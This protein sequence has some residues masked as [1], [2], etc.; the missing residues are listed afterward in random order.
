[1]KQAAVLIIIKDKLILSI[2]RKNNKNKFAL[3]GGKV[4]DGETPEQAIVR[5]VKEE[6]DIDLLKIQYISTRIA[7]KETP[8]GEDFHCH[9]FYAL[10]WK[11]EPKGLEGHE[12]KWLTEKELTSE[13]IGAFPEYNKSALSKLK[14][15][16]KNI[17]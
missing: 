16:Y 5:E 7:E 4:E 15:I 10:L 11:G 12:L 9:C 2:S 6:T 17:L 8:D 14:E 13:E 1:M 3:I